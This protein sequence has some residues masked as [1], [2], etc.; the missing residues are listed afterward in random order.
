MN[1]WSWDNNFSYGT[2]FGL[3]MSSQLCDSL[4]KVSWNLVLQLSLPVLKNSGNLLKD[5]AVRPA[6]ARNSSLDSGIVKVIDVGFQFNIFFLQCFLIPNV[7]SC[8]S[9]FHFRQGIYL[10]CLYL[11]GN[12]R[13]N[14]TRH[15]S[16]ESQRIQ[17]QFEI[18]LMFLDYYVTWEVFFGFLS[19]F[20]F[21][22]L[23]SNTDGALSGK[24]VFLYLPRDTG[25]W[26]G[27]KW[28]SQTMTFFVFTKSV[29]SSRTPISFNNFLS[30][31]FWRNAGCFGSSK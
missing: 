30:N 17:I 24:Y 27:L 21:S 9:N 3:P 20:F 1:N 8:I 23:N 18:H 28:N 26:F 13:Q 12:Q 11:L 31:H 15:Y 14:L 2:D 16:I 5:S 19:F 10:C 29:S 4:L 25:I 7:Q 22:G 6:A